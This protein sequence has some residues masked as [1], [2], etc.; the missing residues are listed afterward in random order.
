[1]TARQLRVNAISARRYRAVRPKN[2]HPIEARLAS[3]AGQPVLHT[4]TTASATPA[5]K[6]MVREARLAP[7]QR[8]CS[9]VV[10]F[11]EHINPEARIGPR[12]RLVLGP[13]AVLGERLQLD[14][15]QGVGRANDVPVDDQAHGSLAVRKRPG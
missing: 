2:A 1:M 14:T 7:R 5:R 13:A 8:P 9:G 4:R 10:N 3:T 11:Y 15:R 12:A 6:R